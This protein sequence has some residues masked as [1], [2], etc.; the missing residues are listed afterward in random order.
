[1]I[2]IYV[3]YGAKKFNYQSDIVPVLGD[4]IIH[5]DVPDDWDKRHGNYEV[6]QRIIHVKN[7]TNVITLTVKPQYL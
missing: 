3:F 1:M 4:L 6:I 7:Q 5:E 2:Y